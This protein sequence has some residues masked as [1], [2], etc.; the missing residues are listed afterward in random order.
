MPE[1][2]P[3]E[4]PS[5]SVRVVPERFRKEFDAP[6][7]RELPGSGER[8]GLPPNY[9]MRADAHYVDQLTS[10]S[11]DMTVRFIPRDEID[12]GGEVDAE[13]VESLAESIRTHGLLQPLLVRRDDNRYRL[14]AG[15]RRLAASALAGLTNVPCVVHQ[16]DERLAEE[17]ARAESVH[18]AEPEQ[19]RAA[20]AF[21]ST[22]L[23][24]QL[25]QELAGIESAAA[26]LVGHPMPVTKRVSL[27][28][29]RAQTS[30][31]TWILQAADLLNR[32]EPN[33]T[34]LARLGPML[35]RT[36]KT[37]LAESRLIGVAIEVCVP[38]WNVSAVIDEE[39]L[40]AGLTGALVA[41]LALLEQSEGAVINL[42][43]SGSDDVVSVDIAQESVA[44]P[45]DVAAR[46]LDP[47]WPSRPGGWPA[48]VGV[49]AA[50]TAALQHGGDVLFQA[51]QGRGSTFRLL[52]GR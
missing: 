18:I 12:G 28:L 38:D 37:C 19:V 50:R 11:P 45:P 32:R 2:D 25:A 27:D 1:L 24:T 52:L 9:R 36:R 31:A 30:R 44:I 35:E 7:E 39:A 13:S 48:V 23:L 15:R 51:R 3:A 22:Q 16:V 46:F 29:V 26:Q 20:P 42:I 8:E 33:E 6:V 17:L 40:A 10:R 21:E 43:L 34:R 47:G 14:I 49:Q 4:V 41:N 5:R